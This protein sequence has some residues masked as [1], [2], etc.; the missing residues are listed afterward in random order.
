[1]D[2]EPIKRRSNS[3]T[4]PGK[5]HPTRLGWLAGKIV[6]DG[7][8]HGRKTGGSGWAASTRS[9][10]KY[11]RTDYSNS[12]AP[13][14]LPTLDTSELVLDYRLRQVCVC[15]ST[16]P[17]GLSSKRSIRIILGPS[18]F[19]PMMTRNSAG[20]HSSTLMILKSSH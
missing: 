17:S 3:A 8:F 13:Y 2:F 11:G 14:G 20:G 1:M 19:G 18:L 16:A 12:S 6:L 9:P 4:D 7:L 5:E 10:T 15:V